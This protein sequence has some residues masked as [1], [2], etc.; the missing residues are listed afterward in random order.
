MKSYSADAD[1]SDLIKAA[2][3]TGDAVEVLVDGERFVVTVA[4]LSGGSRREPL[5]EEEAARSLAGIRR[6][7]G[8]WRG[9]VDAE[10]FKAYIRERR[11]TSSRPDVE[12]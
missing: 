4:P 2:A 5:S 1:L 6:A 8:S 3:K 9:L 12:L 7:A 10:E 11:R